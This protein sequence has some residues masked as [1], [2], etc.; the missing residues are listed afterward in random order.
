MQ[1]VGSPSETFQLHEECAI[2]YLEV[3]SQALIHK[4]K[5]F[6]IP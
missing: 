6:K 3:S 4:S 1:V 5:W 2:W